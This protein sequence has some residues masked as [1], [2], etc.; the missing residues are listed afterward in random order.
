MDED[1]LF[2]PA[3]RDGNEPHRAPGPRNRGGVG[4]GPSRDRATDSASFTIG[5][6]QGEKPKKRRGPALSLAACDRR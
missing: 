2:S 5:V 1:L 4:A 3:A 6:K